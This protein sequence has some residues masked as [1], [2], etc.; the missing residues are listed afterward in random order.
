MILGPGQGELLDRSALSQGEGWWAAAA[1][2]RVQ[3]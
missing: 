2:A 1:A 3:R